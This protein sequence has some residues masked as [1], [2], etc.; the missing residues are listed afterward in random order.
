MSEEDYI[1]KTEFVSTLGLSLHQC[2]ATSHRIERHLTNVCDLLGIHGTFLLT[3]TSFTFCYWRDD[4]VNQHIQIERVQ[5]SDGDLG[6]LDAID[7]LIESFEAKELD[8]DQMKSGVNALCEQPRHYNSALNCISWIVLASSFSALMSDN[9]A[10]ALFSGLLTALIFFIAHIAGKRERTANALELIAALVSGIICSGIAALG[11]PI[12][13]PLV[14]LSTIVIFVPGLALTV[15]LSE[16]AYRDLVSGTS[17][18]VHSIMVLLKLYFGA[19]LGIGLGAALWGHAPENAAFDPITLPE[20][21]ILPLIVMLASSLIVA[22][23]IRPSRTTWCVISAIIGY[24]VAQ[25]SE[26]YFGIAAGMFMGALAVG[27]FSN[28]VANWKN[29]PASIVLSEG[30]I[31]LVPGSKTYIILDAWITGKTMLANQ[32]SNNQTLLIFISLVM[33]LLSA[34]VVLPTRKSL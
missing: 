8:F 10:N 5:P 27:V 1:Q 7:Q 9:A 11:V 23:N 32:I 17:K 4:P 3:P 29:I 14:L 31:V 2:G 6:R 21:R 20:W 34:N 16:I 22:F 28:F 25:L 30:L 33:G 24:Y 26:A 19:M 15:A 13:V 18:L 12:N